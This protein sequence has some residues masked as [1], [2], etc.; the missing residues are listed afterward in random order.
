MSKH[1]KTKYDDFT[2]CTLATKIVNKKL[3]QYVHANN[4]FHRNLQQITV[5]FKAYVSDKTAPL[6]GL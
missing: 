2:F 1:E 5:Y 3:Y 6:P 4:F